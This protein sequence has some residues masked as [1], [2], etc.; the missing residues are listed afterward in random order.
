MKVYG[1]PDGQGLDCQN[2]M[3]HVA[4]EG[5]VITGAHALTRGQSIN[6]HSARSWGFY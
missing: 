3:V 5:H 2:D 6:I 4:G 1:L